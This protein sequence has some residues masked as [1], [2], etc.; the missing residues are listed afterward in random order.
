MYIQNRNK[1]VDTENKLTVT[2]RESEKGG[3]N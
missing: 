3:T 2:N 1:L